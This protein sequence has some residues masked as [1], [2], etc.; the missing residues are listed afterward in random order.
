MNPTIALAQINPTIGDISGNTASIRQAYGEAVDRDATLVVCPELSVIGYPPQ[1]LLHRNRLIQAC[2]SAVH[3]LAKETDDVPLILGSPYRDEG[4]RGKLHNSLFVLRNGRISCI[5]H[6]SLLPTYDVFD[7]ARYFYPE[8]RVRFFEL[9][10]HTIGLTI[11]EDLW[12]SRFLP[13]GVE[14]AFDPV[15]ELREQS[16]DLVVNIAASPYW[17]GKTRN[18]QQIFTGLADDLNASVVYCNTVGANDEIIFDG[19]SLLADP[20]GSLIRQANAFEEDLL[21][22]S[23]ERSEEHVHSSFEPNRKQNLLDAVEL[24]LRDYTRKTGFDKVLIGLSGGIDSGLTA[25]IAA[26]SMGPENVVGVSMPTRFTRSESRS[27]AQELASNLGIEFREIGI[28]DIFES[29]LDTLNPVFDTDDLGVTS[30]NLQARIRGTLL[31]A[32][33][34]YDG[35]L[36][37]AT[38][39]KSEFSVGYCTL[40]GDM[41]GGL[42]PLGDVPKTLVYEL[43]RFINEQSE[44]PVIPENIIKKAPSAELRSDQTDQ[45][46]LPPY[47]TLDRILNEFI[48]HEKD[49]EDILNGSDP[50]LVDEVVQM[51]DRSE[52]KRQQAAPVLKVTS[53]AFGIGRHMPIAKQINYPD[54]EATDD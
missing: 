50:E 11:C 29:F 54:S 31:M 4:N 40:Y 14:Y 49:P 5:S 16:P 43:A 44:P 23:L 33:S 46:T 2:E 48:E 42:A 39:N 41:A 3:S 20:N 22:V 28:E 53:R 10:G 12:P 25:T 6:K 18:R 9:N 30:E 21:L 26:R 1:D 45:D 32:L 8:H 7:E 36:L 38:G 27:D 37:L 51:V 34:N 52:F 17:M 24:G 15:E 47:E 19:Q 13:E 35:H